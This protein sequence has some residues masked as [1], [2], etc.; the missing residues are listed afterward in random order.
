MKAKQKIVVNVGASAIAA[1][2]M[3][4]LFGSAGIG[5][6]TG[7]MT[8]LILVFGEIVPKSFA[9]AKAET[10][11]LLVAR[12][13]EL[14]IAL[15][16][17]VIVL[18]EA[19]TSSAMRITGGERKAPVVT[20]DELRVM[21]SVGVEE[22]TIRKTEREMI[23]SL[24]K[25][26]DIIAEDVMTPRVNMFALNAY[27]ELREALPT[28][29][30]SP[31]SRIPL[32]HGSK[33]NII[34]ILYGRDVFNH[35]A[36]RK[37]LSI[38]LKALAR[39]PFLI[40]KTKNIESLLKEF[41][42]KKIHIAIVID[43]HGGT[44]GLVTL[45]DL[46]EE[47]VGEITDESD[48]SKERIV[49]LDKLTIVVDGGTELRHV[50]RFFNVSIPYKETAPISEFLLEKFGKFPKENEEIVIGSL[51]F[52]IQKADAKKIKRLTVQKT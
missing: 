12:P 37:D 20:E 41:Q 5:I 6:A 24:F 9:S 39:E 25:F 22:G 35:I 43:E 11:A 49:R 30:Q 4:N 52:R 50:N 7:V 18:F 3:T 42:E 47:L 19:L 27:Q 14:L 38:D 23:E 28:I 45:E 8:F 34:G 10:I 32:Y 44:E 13:V 33:D 21:A 1:V 40:P 16:S 31:Y 46:L 29:A 2:A 15:L 17:P 48:V 26:H 51:L 36:Q